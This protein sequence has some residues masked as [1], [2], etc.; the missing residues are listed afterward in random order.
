M[1]EPNVL[2]VGP[3][4]SWLDYRQAAGDGSTQFWIN[5]TCLPQ[6]FSRLVPVDVSREDDSAIAKHMVL[7]C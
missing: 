1:L 2:L 7:R 3:R 4:A 5:G 6:R